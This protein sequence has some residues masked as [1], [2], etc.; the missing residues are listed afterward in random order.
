MS[1]LTFSQIN[2]P[3]GGPR[4]WYLASGPNYYGF[5]S[6]NFPNGFF[7]TENSALVST[8]KSIGVPSTV[9]I[10]LGLGRGPEPRLP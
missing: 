5:L 10:T 2:L 8:R 6:F 9:R 3:V 7:K 4:I 1:Y